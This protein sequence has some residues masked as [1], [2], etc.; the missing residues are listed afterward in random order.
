MTFCRDDIAKHSLEQ[1]LR[2]RRAIAIMHRRG[3]ALLLCTTTTIHDEILLQHAA[4]IRHCAVHIGILMPLLFEE[5]LIDSSA[6]PLLQSVPKTMLLNT[7]VARL[8][9]SDLLDQAKIGGHDSIRD[10]LPNQAGFIKGMDATMEFDLQFLNKWW[11]R[12]ESA[13]CERSA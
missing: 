13:G 11:Q 8:Q 10:V 1:A 3:Y 12:E 2:V 6:H 9:R 7:A 5:D 4:H